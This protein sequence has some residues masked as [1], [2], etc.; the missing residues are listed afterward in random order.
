M[1]FL[2]PA[3]VA[4]HF[5]VDTRCCLLSELRVL[6]AI[7]VPFVRVLL[8]QSV[9][10]CELL[11]LAPCAFCS[12]PCLAA[13]LRCVARIHCSISCS[14]SCSFSI[15]P[16]FP[17]II[18]NPSCLWCGCGVCPAF[19]IGMRLREGGCVCVPL[20]VRAS[21]GCRF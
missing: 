1:L 4:V 14:I 11:F 21:T 6:W 12:F 9:L 17:T 2:I 13:A 8:C 5:I 16:D 10:R 19:L 15:A 18:L 3:V 7:F 20:I